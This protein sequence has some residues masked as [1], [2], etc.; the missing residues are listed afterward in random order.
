MEDLNHH[1]Q[2]KRAHQIG[3]SCIIL[4]VVVGF[5]VFG[6][7]DNIE[8][9]TLEPVASEPL[10]SDESVSEN[11]YK[12]NQNNKQ[13]NPLEIES[14]KPV[15]QESQLSKT[16]Q[17]SKTTEKIIRDSPLKENREKEESRIDQL[18]SSTFV[19]EAN[20]EAYE[21]T[22]KLAEPAFLR[23]VLTPNDKNFVDFDV[24]K[25]V[26]T[27][28]GGIPI[29][30]GFAKIEDRMITIDFTSPNSWMPDMILNGTLDEEIL[31]DSDGE[32][33]VI[34]KEQIVFLTEDDTIPTTLNL[35]GK[36]VID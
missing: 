33:V 13:T 16:E 5:F 24:S 28:G 20:G 22:K 31:E 18:Q 17:N 14:S 9:P 36:L 35:N 2:N 6:F 29:V 34:F 11:N 25:V 12:I 7:A 19:I 30:D 27:A 26:L 1:K 15:L 8:F 23:L 4:S 3:I 21:V 32:I 10:Q